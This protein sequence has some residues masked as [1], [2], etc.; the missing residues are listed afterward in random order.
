[1]P[2]LFQSAPDCQDDILKNVIYVTP[3]IQ[4]GKTQ[5]EDLLTEFVNL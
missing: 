1:M 2:E 5:P 4:I 3:I